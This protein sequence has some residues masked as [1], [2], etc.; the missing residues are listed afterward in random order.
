MQ[1]HKSEINFVK[2]GSSGIVPNTGVIID[3][4][5]ARQQQSINYGGPKNYTYLERPGYS[6]VQRPMTRAL[7]FD[8]NY[9]PTIAD[10]YKLVDANEKEYSAKKALQAQLQMGRPGKRGFRD[11]RL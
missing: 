3:P 6:Y 11:P 10:Q 1:E 4:D 8:D 2:V 9:F 5:D 7:M